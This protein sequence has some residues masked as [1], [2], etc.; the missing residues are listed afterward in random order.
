MNK[1][2]YIIFPI[3]LLQ[4][5]VIDKYFVANNI[6]EWIES[7]QPIKKEPTALLN[8]DYYCSFFGNETTE[9]E[10]MAFAFRAA[11]SSIIGRNKA[12]K[13]NKAFVL[14]RAFG[15]NIP[16]H[17]DLEDPLQIQYNKY[18][19]RH[20][21]DKIMKLLRKSGLKRYGR[22][23]NGFYLSYKLS[24]DELAFIAESKKKKNIESLERKKT[25]R[26]HENALKKLE[27]ANH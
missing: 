19:V 1:K 24:L 14:T 18:Y 8:Y 11:I 7:E 23:V 16:K 27:M 3:R 21:F 17:L 15:Y 25:K 6:V 5:L 4:M 26:A 20:H 10:V 9:E 12:V 13:T 22:G 2:E